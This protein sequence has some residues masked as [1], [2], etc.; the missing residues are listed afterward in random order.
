MQDQVLTCVVKRKRYIPACGSNNSARII[1]HSAG[2]R[3]ALTER[4]L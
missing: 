3:N 2:I 1:Q 4:I